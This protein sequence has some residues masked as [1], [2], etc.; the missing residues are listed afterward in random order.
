LLLHIPHRGGDLIFT[1]FIAAD[2][3]G[4]TDYVDWPENPPEEFWFREQMT[5][6]VNAAIEGALDAGADSI[7]VSDI[8]WRKQNII[9]DKLL[10]CA[11]LIRGSK[12]KLMWMDFVERSNFVFLIGFHS[13]FGP[14]DAVLP[15]TI[16]TRITGLKI[17]GQNVD[18][19]YISAATAGYFGVPVGLATGDMAFVKELK[20]LL[21]D[22]ETVAVK[23]AVGNCAAL[24]LH[25]KISL[26]E[27][28][29]AA[30]VAVQKGISGGFK[31][32]R[33]GNLLEMAIEVS[34]PSYAD[35]LSLVPGVVRT[36]GTG[37][38]YTGDWL[39]ALGILSL[40]VNWIGS[41]RLL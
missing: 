14:A 35:A 9:P 37:V 3:E 32:Y 34:W 38:S 24:N 19:A 39:N 7:I 5:A 28:K 8:H 11:S 29:K 20:R 22:V 31:P 23:E 25:P 15:H 18:E 12:R 33:P 27:I 41:K 4:I 6:E 16:D 10:G 1:I 2:I 17:N 36:S 26:E 40:F 21:P 30:K 13:G